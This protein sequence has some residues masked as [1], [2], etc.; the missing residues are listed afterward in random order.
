MVS[1]F[2]IAE[3]G[4]DMLR[5]AAIHTPTPLATAMSL[6]AAILIG[7]IAVKTGCSSTRSSCIWQSRPSACSL[8]QATS[9]DWPT[10]LSG[11]C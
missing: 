6:I 3:I 1:Q 9:W 2:L 5:M 4:V 7:D 8:R 10:G 11:W